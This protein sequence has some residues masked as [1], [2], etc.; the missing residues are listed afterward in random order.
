MSIWRNL[1]CVLKDVCE[2]PTR[3]QRMYLTFMSVGLSIFTIGPDTAHAFTPGME[4]YIQ[5][6]FGG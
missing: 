3:S 6:V 5:G 4:P 2:L 1:S